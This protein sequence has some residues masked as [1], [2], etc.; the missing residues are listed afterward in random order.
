MQTPDIDA[1]FFLFTIFAIPAG[2]VVVELAQGLS[3][4]LRRR[5]EVSIGWLTPAVAYL[6][7]LNVA[8]LLWSMWNRRFDLEPSSPAIAIGLIIASLYYVAAS[9]TF[10]HD[11]D[12]HRSLDDWFWQNR[13]FTIGATLVIAIVIKMLRGGTFENIPDAQGVNILAYILGWLLVSVPMLLAAFARN[14]KL[15]LGAF[16]VL[17]VMRTAAALT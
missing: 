3:H 2:L 15:A 1:F 14:R 13:G 16:V 10:P 11:L 5:H 4:A 8:G 7:L 9:F 12:R 17:L 6:L